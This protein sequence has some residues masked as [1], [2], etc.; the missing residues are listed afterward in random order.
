[1]SDPKTPSNLLPR[2][3]PAFPNELLL[4]AESQWL[5]TESELRRTPSVLDG[6]T[7][8]K[9]RDNRGKGVNFIFQVGIMLKLP[10]I[11]LATASVFL[12]RFFMRH[13]MVDVPGRPGLHYYAI[14][15]TSLFLASKVEE[16]CRK[17]KELVVACVRV[18]Q[19]NPNKVVDEQDKEY[20]RWKDTI[21]QY[22]D[23]L[24]EANCFDLSL[25]PPY[26]TL[27]EF[28]LFFGEENHKR[29]R[30]AAWAFVNDSCLTMLCLLFPSRTIAA[31]ALYAAAKHC[32]VSFL[33]D[34]QGR[35]W[36]EAVGVE[37]KNIRRAINYMA[38][39]YE[40]SPLKGG[41]E[42]SIY[43]RTPEDGDEMVAKTRATRSKDEGTPVDAGLLDRLTAGS[44]RSDTGSEIG[45][46]KREREE[47]DEGVKHR[48]AVNGTAGTNGYGNGHA[49]G[50]DIPWGGE[51]AEE[52]ESKRRKVEGKAGDATNQDRR[53]SDDAPPT[54]PPTH[55]NG[56]VSPNVDDV[57][58]EGE[59]EP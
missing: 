20:W 43:E 24:L 35:P 12:H 54:Q 21:L 52:R 16:N 45:H 8:E 46:G 50:D 49:E 28:L 41:V 1:M 27:F 3:P 29:L 47:D 38:G 48:P 5:F 10:Q 18:A 32:G 26:K 57:S 6:L 37:L 58:E 4:Q 23:L 22:E 53:H 34:Q 9:E 19:K 2:Q 7:P 31:S 36:W 42:G 56:L 30:N 59:V 44:V 13:S 14:A 25:E 11:T 51:T 40:N 15:A 39:I 17:M 33:D 55:R